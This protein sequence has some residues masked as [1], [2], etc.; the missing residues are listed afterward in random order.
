MRPFAGLALVLLLACAA[1]KGSTGV[2]APV[3]GR[4]GEPP[5]APLAES[6]DVL[7]E[8]EEDQKPSFW[9]QG[10][11]TF[12][13]RDSELY[14]IEPS[15]LSVLAKLTSPDGSLPACIMT[16][17]SGHRF[18]FASESGQLSLWGSNGTLIAKSERS[19]GHTVCLGA[20]PRSF[21]VSWD[22]KDDRFLTIFDRDPS[23]PWSGVWVWRNTG[24]ALEP[25][26]IAPPGR[27]GQVDFLEHG[28]GAWLAR[29]DGSF[30]IVTLAG[31]V[32][33]SFTCEQCVPSPNGQRIAV[34]Q[35]DPQRHTR[36]FD[37]ATGSALWE[38]TAFSAHVWS[39]SMRWLLGT[40]DRGPLVIDASNG[41]IVARWAQSELRA[42]VAAR[43]FGDLLVETSARESSPLA[44]PE[45][46]PD[47]AALAAVFTFRTDYRVAFWKAGAART[48]IESGVP[49][50][51][52]PEI[53]SSHEGDRFLTANTIWSVKGKRLLRLEALAPSHG[54]AEDWSADDRYLGGVNDEGLVVWDVRT[55]RIVSRLEYPY[56]FLEKYDR[57]WSS[58]GHELLINEGPSL[59]RHSPGKGTVR[60][61]PK[62]SDAELTF[63]LEEI[64]NNEF[65][66]TLDSEA[67]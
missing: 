31:E 34:N 49:D 32:S 28:A 9:V 8:D 59:L 15:S 61:T 67:P 20:V 11:H 18:L 13:R 14:L 58:Q 54:S 16:H 43:W 17:P 12:V 2:V 4:A 40:D 24:S 22:V 30:Q 7:D 27:Y 41:R 6:A 37:V 3:A 50:E 48:R 19:V 44:R 29:D 39:P 21:R 10:G 46:S 26:R 5:K 35:F 57:C 36:L 66:P 55:G 47:K 51:G 63:E 53:T 60:I 56:R 42:G 23:L 62:L 64:V 1:E 25:T 52:S 33:G 38:S 65:G 45:M